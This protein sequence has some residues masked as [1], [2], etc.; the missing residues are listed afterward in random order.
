MALVGSV[1]LSRRALLLSSAAALGCG[2]A[3]KATGYPGY[4]FV[5]N[6]GSRSVAVVDL[7]TFRR[8]PAIAIPDTPSAVI[9]HPSQ[10]KAFVLAPQA[11]TVFEL[12]AAM[13]AVSRRV[14]AGR[15]AV[16]MKLAQDGTALWVLY[17]KP[18]ALLEI[19]LDSLQP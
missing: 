17:R 15:E 19:P 18:A 13:L 2:G 1:P 4:C 6:A 3:R 11:G 10:P 7:L 12:D 9:A 14:H 16:S 5:A 8:L